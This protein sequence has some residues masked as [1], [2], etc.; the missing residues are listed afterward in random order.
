MPRAC[1]SSRRLV[2]LA[3]CSSPLAACGGG[4]GSPTGPTTTPTPPGST[5]NVTAFYDENGN[6]RL[7]PS[8]AARVPGVEV[9]IGGATA[10]TAKNT[11]LAVVSGVLEGAQTVDLRSDSLPT[12]YQPGPPIPI[13]VP[14]TTDVKYPLTL[15]IGQNN[16]SV[17]LGYGDSITVGDGSSDGKGYALRLQSLLGP[18][19]GRAEVETWGREGTMSREGATRTHTT[20]GWFHPAY[21]L[22]LYGTNDWNDQTCQNQGPSACFTIDFAFSSVILS[23]LSP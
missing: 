20:L 12:Y 8:E 3:L 17:Y 5:V 7:D 11:G 21:L 16:A 10:K 6:G 15:P 23:M 1:L 13:Q 4:G 2:V 14:G 19:F 9:V 18:Y 22:I